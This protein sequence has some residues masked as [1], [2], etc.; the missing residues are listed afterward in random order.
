MSDNII[1]LN[2]ELIHNELK[3]LVRN[4]VEEPFNAFSVSDI[5]LECPEIIFILVGLYQTAEDGS[6][7]R[8]IS[9]VEWT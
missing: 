1:Q 3:D 2:Q 5:A 9:V 7:C 6:L 8:R 4:S